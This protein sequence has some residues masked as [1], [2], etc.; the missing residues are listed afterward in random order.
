MK[1]DRKSALNPTSYNTTHRMT[2]CLMTQLVRERESDFKHKP[3]GLCA[4]A[5]E[6]T[7]EEMKN[8]T[9]PQFK[10]LKVTY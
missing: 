5:A 7:G 10:I 2:K 8:A 3:S 6:G 1:H 4:N 9:G